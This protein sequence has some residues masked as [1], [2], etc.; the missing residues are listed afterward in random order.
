ME[1][2]KITTWKI[3]NLKLSKKQ[4]KPVKPSM[5]QIAMFMLTMMQYIFHFRIE[6]TQLNYCDLSTNNFRRY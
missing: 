6:Y 5:L 3:V 1:E 4:F 2:K